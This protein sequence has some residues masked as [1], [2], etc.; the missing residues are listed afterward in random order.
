MIQTF[1]L[2]WLSSYMLWMIARNFYSRNY[3]I[4]SDQPDS[5]HAPQITED[6][7]RGLVTEGF[8]SIAVKMW[9]RTLVHPFAVLLLKSSLPRVPLSTIDSFLLSSLPCLLPFFIFC[10]SES[11]SKSLKNFFNY[12]NV[13]LNIFPVLKEHADGCIKHNFWI[14]FLNYFII[15]ILCY[16]YCNLTVKWVFIFSIF[17][18]ISGGVTESLDE[19]LQPLVCLKKAL[20]LVRQNL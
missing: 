3:F 18:F 2:G 17:S 20:W 5:P 14:N 8:L 12:L 11:I 19:N 9:L 6:C 7:L 13:F 1:A 4:A 15:A 16:W 10:F